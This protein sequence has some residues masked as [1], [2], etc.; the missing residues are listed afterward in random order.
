MKKL[1]KS[2]KKKRWK[3]MSAYKYIDGREL[4][5]ELDELVK[6][7]KMRQTEKIDDE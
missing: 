3:K 7:Y 5:E 1:K 6:S 2:K 4:I